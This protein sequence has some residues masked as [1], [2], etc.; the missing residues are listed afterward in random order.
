MQEFLFMSQ[1]AAAQTNW[2]PP[3]PGELLGHPKQLWMLFATE[4]W[5]RFCFYGFRW[6]LT[7]YIVAQFYGGDPKGE[8]NASSTYGAYLALVY[9]TS[10]LGGYAADRI[11]GYQ[12]AVLLGAAII[13]A[14]LFMLLMPSREM[15][16]WSLAV[17]VV[18][19]G[20]FKPNISS[21]VGRLYSPTDN[22]R[23][24]GFTIF[25]MG[26]NAGAFFA[27][28]IT[29]YVA[30]KYGYLDLNPAALRAEGFR[31]GFVCAGIGMLISLVWF[32]MGKKSLGIVGVPPAG[33]ESLGSMMPAIIG[34]IIMVP[35]MYFLMNHG[36]WLTL[37]LSSLFAVCVGMLLVA[38]VKDGNIQ[39]DKVIALLILFL[40]NVLFW[41]FFEQAGSSFN[42]LAEK[43]VDR[44][45][46][47]GEFSV[48]WFQSV[49]PAAIVLLAPVLTIIWAFTDKR[50]MEPSIPR[51]FAFGL[52]GNALGFLVLMYA[53]KHLVDG[54]GMIPFWT[55]ALCYVFQTMGELCLSPIGL[56]MVTKLAPARMVGATMG[57]WF[58]S[59]SIGNKLAGEFAA[60][61]SGE[62]GMTVSSALHG[63][64]LSFYLLLGFGVLLFLIAPLINKLMH[65]VK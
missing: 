46:F 1:S 40:F 55:L 57:A 27:P 48:G 4:F 50:G 10:I 60:R 31:A 64:N 43:I 11:L 15:F 38:G 2:T 42:F 34:A 14:G 32:W 22:R 61:I 56:S 6:M 36:S 39:R 3:P 23:D 12:R 24:R 49:N 16:T 53:L 21:M 47:G 52:L 58:L 30:Q 18:G 17:I 5:E 20:L 7:L 63:F 45:M 13:A 8:E 35:V 29:G 51:K 9:A 37:I 33:K 19:N 65:G 59:I 62:T 41:M 28:L 26:I 44:N 25:Y 54:N